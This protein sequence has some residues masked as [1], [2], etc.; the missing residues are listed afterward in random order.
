MYPVSSA[1]LLLRRQRSKPG[2]R[3][4]Q[5][6]RAASSSIPT[7]PGCPRRPAGGPGARVVLARPGPW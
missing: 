7:P 2:R 3:W 5:P 6:L 4:P 1:R